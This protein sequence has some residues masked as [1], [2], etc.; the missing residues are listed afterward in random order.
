L[1]NEYCAGSARRHRQSRAFSAGGFFSRNSVRKDRAGADLVRL[2]H[3]TSGESAAGWAASKR[4]TQEEE[5]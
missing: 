4:F 5:K 3:A 1:I 2:N